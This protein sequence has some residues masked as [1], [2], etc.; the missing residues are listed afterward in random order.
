MN[1]TMTENSARASKR[2]P[3]NGD[4][5]YIAEKIFKPSGSHVVIYRAEEQG[6][7]VGGDKYAVVCSLHATISSDT[8]IPGARMSM[9]YP[10][11]CEE[12]MKREMTIVRGEVA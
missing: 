6:I 10:A 7:D 3:H 1:D 2:K 12:C 9:K 5:G 11:F 8:N 4:A